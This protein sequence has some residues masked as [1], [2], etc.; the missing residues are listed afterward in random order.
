MMENK[1]NKRKLFQ[2]NDFTGM[3]D[4]VMKSND[5]NN[6]GSSANKDGLIE[7]GTTKFK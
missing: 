3:V 2:G 5:F 7:K 6:M 4:G 1:N